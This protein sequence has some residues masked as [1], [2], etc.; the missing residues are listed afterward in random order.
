MYYG[1]IRH[2]PLYHL[3]A[4]L[5]NPAYRA[6]AKRQRERKISGSGS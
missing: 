2:N 6:W 3:A 5:L 4:S 1:E